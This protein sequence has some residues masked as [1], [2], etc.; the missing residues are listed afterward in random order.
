MF[1][2][3]PSHALSPFRRP[4]ARFAWS[5]ILVPI[6][7][8]CTTFQP[9]ETPLT[10]GADTP[11]PIPDDQWPARRTEK[12]AEIA[13]STPRIVGAVASNPSP[14]NSVPRP[15]PRD[16]H[17]AIDLLYCGVHG[18]GILRVMEYPEHPGAP[19]S[20]A[21]G[22]TNLT[23]RFV[24]YSKRKDLPSDPWRANWA[25]RQYTYWLRRLS[26]LQI[27]PGDRPEK[28]GPPEPKPA[29]TGGVR[30]LNEGTAIHVIMPPDGTMARGTVVYMC[31]L[32]SARYE[33]PLMDELTRRGWVMVRIA[34]P[35]VWWYD[36]KPWYIA[37]RED[38]PRVAENLAAVMD[39]MVAEPAYAAQ[40][41]LEYLAE[42]RPDIPQH[43]LVMFG[44]SCGALAAPAVVARNFE[45]FDA[46][47]L[48]G[49]G[50]NLLQISQTSDLTDGGIHLAWPNNQPRGPWREA[51]FA[52]Y[53]K[54]AKLDPYNTARF[55][56]NK[57]TL[58]V[59][60]NLDMTVPAHN[61]WL[62]WDRLGRPDRYE[63]IGEHRTLFLTLGGQSNRIADWM[64]D[65][66]GRLPAPKRYAEGLHAE[67][68]G[69]PG[70]A[71]AP[72]GAH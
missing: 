69:I 34:T 63:H 72:V 60:A 53:L 67:Q 29:D 23:M 57:P 44:C 38:V 41:A 54:F 70:N 56:R 64:D 26:E 31:G 20:S 62:L 2:R 13:A 4:L 37:S 49:A 65:Q 47:V 11:I 18:P 59:Q 55:L 66:A 46:A 10:A 6:L 8:G 16:T 15:E 3:M 12:L 40:A 9:R 1:A 5:A 50:A 27:A 45:R 51:L 52:E 42:H 22:S 24:S 61:G 36:A 14:P 35:R 7:A 17:P 19:K 25:E 21:N 48:V 68:I 58:M 39:D 30:L 28:V 71:A 43:P 33:Q 32:G